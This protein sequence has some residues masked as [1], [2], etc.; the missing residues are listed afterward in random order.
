[1][2]H[3]ARR[4]I[5]FRVTVSGNMIAFIHDQNPALAGFG[6]PLGDDCTG[7]STSNYQILSHEIDL[8]RV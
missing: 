7:K 1:M 3:D 8:L 2:H 4:A 5:S 6:Q